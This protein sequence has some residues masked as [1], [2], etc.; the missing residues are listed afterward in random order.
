MSLI[1]AVKT[2]KQMTLTISSNSMEY[3][4]KE[5]M[6]SILLSSVRVF[7]F[8][9]NILNKIDV[10]WTRDNENNFFSIS[11]NGETKVKRIV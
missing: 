11:S 8:K 1:E 7:N 3:Q 2:E 5:R 6:V 9:C 10:I 4:K